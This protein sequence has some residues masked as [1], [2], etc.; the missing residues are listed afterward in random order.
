MWPIHTLDKN[1]SIFKQKYSKS[2]KFDTSQARFI[3]RLVGMKVVST[4]V[5]L[6]H[7]HCTSKQSVWELTLVCG[8]YSVYAH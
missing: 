3:C 2:S 5:L 6:P 4:A 8:S 7:P 1:G